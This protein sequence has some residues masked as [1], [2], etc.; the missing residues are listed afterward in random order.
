M[1]PLT[2]CANGCDRPPSP[3]SKVICK[4]CQKE[5]GDKLQALADKLKRRKNEAWRQ[6]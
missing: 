5:I 6:N 2:K 4:E 3:P 1:K